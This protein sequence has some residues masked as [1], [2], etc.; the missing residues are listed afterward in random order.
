ML[1]MNSG[2]IGSVWISIAMACT[3]ISLVLSLR[4]KVPK[5]YPRVENVL[6]V[7]YPRNTCVAHTSGAAPGG[8]G[9]SRDVKFLSISFCDFLTLTRELIVCA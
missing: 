7:T 1:S 5:N 6:G 3:V 2:V 4:A 8:R 9:G